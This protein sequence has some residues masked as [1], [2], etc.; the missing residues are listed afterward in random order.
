MS[1]EKKKVLVCTPS[2]DGKLNVG[3]SMGAFDLIRQKNDL[4]SNVYPSIFD[5]L[6]DII[7]AVAIL[8]QAHGQ[9]AI[10]NATMPSLV[11]VYNVSSFR[12]VPRASEQT[13]MACQFDRSRSGFL[14]EDLFRMHKSTQVPICSDL[15]REV[16]GP[17]ARRSC[18]PRPST[19]RQTAR[20]S[21]GRN[22]R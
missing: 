1:E 10:R 5:E 22:E 18:F 3:Y 14:R 8:A 13:T 19:F 2:H 21:F 12:S 11:I 15:R 16:F 6:F 20:Q 9:M 17:Q 4:F 7:L